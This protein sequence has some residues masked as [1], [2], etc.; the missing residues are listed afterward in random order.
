MNNPLTIIG[1]YAEVL[2]RS[3]SA[4]EHA[5]LTA[6]IKGEVRRVDDIISYYLHRQEAPDFLDQG[7]DLNELIRET[8]ESLHDS[9][10]KSGKIE[11]QLNLQEELEKLEASPVLIKQI[12]VNLIRNAAEALESGGI[13][14]LTTRVNFVGGP[15]LA[16]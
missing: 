2:S 11:L 7:V 14:T 13:I 4:Q 10:L 1:N 5:K 12:L 9:V 8:V 3:D 6:A 16:G 15:R